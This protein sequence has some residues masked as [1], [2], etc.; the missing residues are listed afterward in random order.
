MD[1]GSSQHLGTHLLCILDGGQLKKAAKKYCKQNQLE[2]ALKLAK[3]TNTL[4][5]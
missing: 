1:A 2:D 5:V 3:N 4:A